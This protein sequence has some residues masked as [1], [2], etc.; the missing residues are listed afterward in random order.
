MTE[1]QHTLTALFDT[2]SEAARAVEHLV[3]AKITRAEIQVLLGEGAPSYTRPS[4]QAFYDHGATRAG[5]RPR[6]SRCGCPTR[7]GTPTRKA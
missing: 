2:R 6:S 4:G 5:S 3:G 7:T 1:Q